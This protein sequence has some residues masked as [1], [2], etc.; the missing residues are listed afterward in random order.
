ML[1][2]RLRQSVKLR[3]VVLFKATITFFVPQKKIVLASG[4][5][6]RLRQSVKPQIPFCTKRKVVALF[7]YRTACLVRGEARKSVCHT[8]SS[9]ESGRQSGLQIRFTHR[10]L[11]P[12]NGKS[13]FLAHTAGVPPSALGAVA[14]VRWVVVG[15]GKPERLAR[16]VWVGRF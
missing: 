10:R 5:A 11:S 14:W 9:P 8:L 1:A 13:D 7:F 12:S 4:G 15:I 2:D 6:D 16:W 3:S